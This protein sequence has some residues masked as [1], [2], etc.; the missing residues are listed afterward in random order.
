[1]LTWSKWADKEHISSWFCRKW[2]VP[3]WEISPKAACVLA[4]LFLEQQS[5]HIFRLNFLKQLCLKSQ[6]SLARNHISVIARL[7][8]AEAS[9]PKISQKSGFV[10]CFYAVGLTQK[11]SQKFQAPLCPEG[12][13]SHLELGQFGFLKTDRWNR[14]V[15]LGSPK[16][17]RCFAQGQVFD[18]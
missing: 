18:V 4:V 3:M 15:F 9:A 12:I 2:H 7:M 16:C 6:V 17:C 11:C 5:S 14:C 10:C 13:W 1:M 8:S